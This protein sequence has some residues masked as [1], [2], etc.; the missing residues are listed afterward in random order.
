M[1]VLLDENLPHDLR[2]FLPGHEVFTVAYMGWNSIENGE[3]LSTAAKDGFEVM[4]TADAGVQYQQHPAALPLSVLV[5]RC[6]SNRL[7]DLR[8]LLPL[9]LS[10]LSN[11]SPRTLVR[12]G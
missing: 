12:V 11:L 6:K 10:A 1:K 2:L 8:P 9:V 3:L 5:M 7:E 4:L